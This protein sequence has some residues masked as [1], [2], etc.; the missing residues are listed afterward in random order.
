MD[1][2]VVANYFGNPPRVFQLWL[3]SCGANPG[4]Q[5]LFMT[6]IDMS[7][8]R[9]PSNMTVQLSDFPSLKSRIQ[10]CFPYPVRYE[11]PWDF[12]ALK[13]LIGTIFSQE[14]IGADY[15]GWSDCD[16]LYG[17]LSPVIRLA[18]QGYDK[19][20]PNGHFSLVKNSR[21]LNQFILNHP[22]T[23]EAL[24]KS[25]HGLSCFDERDFRFT[26]MHDFGARQASEIVPYIHVYPRWGH[27]TFNVSHAAC[28]ELGIENDESVPVVFT[29]CKGRLTG[30][31]AM[32]DHTVKNLDLAYVHFF[33]RNIKALTEGLKR[34]GTVY[35]VAPNGIT[36]LKRLP[37]FS[38]WE[39]RRIDR[40]RLHWHY[41]WSRLTIA[42]LVRKYKSLLRKFGRHS[43]AAQN[44]KDDIVFWPDC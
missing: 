35:L 22:K 37:E 3:D 13:P 2:R 17:D 36:E 10:A 38:Y 18:E 14:L 41:I 30:H 15:W 21:E 24:R 40:P 7:K 4:V 39:I 44:Q 5:W 29:W 20:M 27:F 8:Y 25:G 31:F 23:V 32:Y 26:V 34:D 19:I 43:A 33:K 42:T 12:C 1:I 9:V 16:M 28:R 11:R 6:D